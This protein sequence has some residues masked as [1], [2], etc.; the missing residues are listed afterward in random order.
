MGDDLSVGPSLLLVLAA[1]DEA[2]HERRWKDAVK[3]WPSPVAVTEVSVVGHDIAGLLS[4][5]D[6]SAARI[7]RHFTVAVLLIAELKRFASEIS[8]NS[9]ACRLPDRTSRLCDELPLELAGN[10]IGELDEGCQEGCISEH[11]AHI[12]ASGPGAARKMLR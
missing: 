1:E 6:A 3:K 5:G 2:Y 12:A 7:V 8:R 9:A 10:I 4:K 11:V